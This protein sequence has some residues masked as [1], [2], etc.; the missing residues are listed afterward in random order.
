MHDTSQVFHLCIC[1]TSYIQELEDFFEESG[2]HGVVIF[3]LGTVVD[4]MNSEMKEMIAGALARLPQ[5]VL[6]RFPGEP[7]K[8]L[9]PNTK[10][11][12]WLPQND[13]LGE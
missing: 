8:N 11:V 12:S 3:S 9:G 6:W 4:V 5:R 1:T 10:L 7:P 13:V 2:K